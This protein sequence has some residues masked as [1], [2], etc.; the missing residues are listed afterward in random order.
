[1][2]KYNIVGA[3]DRHNYGDIL[4]PLI[5]SE[6]IRRHSE[7]AEINYY[8][9]SESN[10]ESIGGVRTKSIMMLHWVSGRKWRLSEKCFQSIIL[11]RIRTCEIIIFG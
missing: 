1:M 10:L 2:R 4:F 9:L 5:H 7:S 3:F 11:F 6:F 8:S